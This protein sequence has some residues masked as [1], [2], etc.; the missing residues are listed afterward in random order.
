MRDAIALRQ[1][2]VGLAGVPALALAFGCGS[3]DG[4]TK[5]EGDKGARK[6]EGKDGKGER[7]GRLAE[8]RKQREEKRAA[9]KAE[10]ADRAAAKPEGDDDGAAA[11]VP[12]SAGHGH[13]ASAPVPPGTPAQ[14][15]PIPGDPPYV[16][17]YNPEEETC[18]SGNW[19][20]TKALAQALVPKGDTTP[21]LMQCPAR[22]T[23]AHEPSP[24]TG[25]AYEG[26]S[27]KR[28]MQGS[29]NEGRTKRW[30]AEGKDDTCCYHWFE[31]CSG[32]PLLDGGESIVAQPRSGAV[33]LD[34]EVEPEVD[35]LPHE[36]RIALARAWL[37]DALREHASI[38]SFA[39][40]TMELMAHAAPP[41][42][43]SACMQAGIE[44]V[45]H[46]R[47]CLAL[48]SAY[49]DRP[50]APG[51]LPALPPRDQGLAQ[52]AV[53]TFLEGCVGETVAALVAERAL[54]QATD[55]A[56]RGTLR[57]IVDDESRHAALAWRT[58]AWALGQGGV[59]VRH[60]MASMLEH[61][62]VVEPGDEPPSGP[63][64]RQAL[65]AHGRLDAVALAQT[66]SD[67]WHDIVAPM[68][69]NLL[70]R[71]AAGVAATSA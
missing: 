32:R 53:E 25:A 67:A 36:A 69:A 26:L 1:R 56:V 35:G 65:R 15:L 70:G 3:A 51:P 41:E 16:D 33:W 29:F 60:A 4:G 24:I 9:M 52:L 27:A 39:R 17:G 28:Q 6:V 49:A 45:D 55:E 66:V 34:A 10:S 8:L 37:D 59:E 11:P 38:A 43:V 22:I 47:R 31:Y 12:D 7:K 44:E 46:A 20:G 71:R 62:P 58:V 19:C 40:A 50:I 2:L 57:V 30:R 63:A 54:A 48:A 61:P 18:P 14:Y 42:L 13:S 68:L 5:A 23:G 64:V 21:E